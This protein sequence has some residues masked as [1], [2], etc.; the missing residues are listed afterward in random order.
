MGD[1]ERLNDINQRIWNDGFTDE[2]LKYLDIIA[3]DIKNGAAV[4]ERI[5][6]AQ[7]SGL[8][9]GTEV[10]CAA[11]IICRG[12][13]CTE[14]ETR[15]IYDTD[16]LVGEAYIQEHLVET[17]AR[18]SGL[19]IENP[20]NYLDN[21][22]HLQDNGTESVVYFDVFNRIV[23]K[24]ISLK[25]YN[26]LRL[27]L[28]RIIIHNALFP[29]TFLKVLGF[30]RDSLGSF[31]VVVSQPYVIG[32]II[33]ESDR[34]SFMLNL[35]F[36]DAGMDYGMHLNYRTDYLYVGDLNEYNVIRGELGVNVVDADCRLNVS[37]LECGGKYVIPQPQID[38]SEPFMEWKDFLYIRNN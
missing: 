15:Q 11:S 3:E 22:C 20:E 6:Y 25:H 27:A 36:S 2:N 5:P 4:F 12:C 33:D 34:R 10:L 7:Q 13:P 38:F 35:G 29:E 19:W 31:V 14:S 26:V 18:L 28:D 23:Y 9:K 16:D 8:S 1:F 30:A 32:D 21:L 37:T 24:L 17:W